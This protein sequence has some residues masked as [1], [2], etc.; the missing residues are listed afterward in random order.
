MPPV[1][2]RQA[3]TDRYRRPHR[4]IPQK[5]SKISTKETKAGLAT[6]ALNYAAKLTDLFTSE[7]SVSAWPHKKLP[8]ITVPNNRNISLSENQ[9]IAKARKP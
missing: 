8:D 4:T 3:K 7:R 1:F 6:P 2:Y 9:L 5:V